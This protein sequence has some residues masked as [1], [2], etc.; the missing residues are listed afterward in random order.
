MPLFESGFHSAA[1]LNP[2][3]LFRDLR[4]KSTAVVA[5]SW[6]FSYDLFPDVGFSAPRAVDT[7][8]KASIL[9]ALKGSNAKWNLTMSD[10]EFDL[11]LNYQLGAGDTYFSAKMIARI[12]RLVTIADEVGES[13]TSYFKDMLSRLTQRLEV[14]LGQ[15]AK[16]LDPLLY[17]ASWGGVVACGCEYDDCKGTCL[18]HCANN[19]TPPEACPALRDP[20]ANFGNAFYNDHHFHYG[21]FVYA[22]AVA[23]KYNPSWELQWRQEILT[24]VRDYANPSDADT[25]FPV[26]RHKDWFLGFSWAGGIPKPASMNGRNQESTS[27]AI[28]AYFAVYAYGAAVDSKQLKDLGRILTAMEVHSSD[29]YW[30]VSNETDIYGKE[31]PFPYPT[32]G[33]IWSNMVNHQTYFGMETFFVEGIHLMPFIPVMES[34][35]KP[36]WVATQFPPYKAACDNDTRCLDGGFSWQVCLEQGLVDAA[37]AL[38]CLKSLPGDAFSGANPGSNGNSLTNSLHWLATRLPAP[39]PPSPAPVPQAWWKNIFV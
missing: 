17:D 19:V 30:H 12:A 2:P 32:V 24:L 23:A 35:L 33:Q 16:S 22:A 20:G 9:D 37:G 18:P 6:K 8:M 14:W 25:S 26:T 21:Y 38:E 34:Y 3:A 36:D 10:S 31:F 15:G 29:T 28:N 1:T 11:P 39:S 27:E 4:G 13:S 5:D 7:S